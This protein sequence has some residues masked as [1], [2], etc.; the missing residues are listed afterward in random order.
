MDTLNA[1]QCL[2]L[3]AGVARLPGLRSKAATLLRETITPLML[4]TKLVVILCVTGV[5]RFST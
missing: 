1:I 3:L 2:N 5:R 4:A